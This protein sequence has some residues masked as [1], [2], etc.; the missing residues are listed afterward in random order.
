MGESAYF[1]AQV[2][3]LLQHLNQVHTSEDRMLSI[4]TTNCWF[5]VYY[6]LQDAFKGS[7]GSK[8]GQQKGLYRTAMALTEGHYQRT[9]QNGQFIFVGT[10]AGHDFA[11]SYEPDAKIDC[12][13][14]HRFMKCETQF[15]ADFYDYLGDAQRT[16]I[17]IFGNQTVR[18]FT[19]EFGRFA[20][21]ERAIKKGAKSQ[22]QVI[23]LF[24]EWSAVYTN[25]QCPG[26][27]FVAGEN[28]DDFLAAIPEFSVQR[29]LVLRAATLDGGVVF[30]PEAVLACA[31]EGNYTQIAISTA[32]LTHYTVLSED[33]QANLKYMYEG[34]FYG[35]YLLEQC[36]AVLVSSG[37]QEGDAFFEEY[38]GICCWKK[39][40]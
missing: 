23:Q 10:V 38:R 32:L 11:F 7:K 18:M 33:G 28:L 31:F 20:V 37:W 22:Q 5:N 14:S 12:R 4:V 15:R 27:A 36:G 24:Q 29:D 13:G 30:G 25:I 39:Y 34:E 21:E 3:R 26:A 8:D 1:S 40:D 19:H 6:E 17:C 2:R 9:N 35:Q 16:A